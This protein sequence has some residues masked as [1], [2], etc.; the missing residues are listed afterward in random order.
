MLKIN[1]KSETSH[2]FSN[3]TTILVEASV[4][5]GWGL[6]TASSQPPCF[7]PGSHGMFCA[8]RPKRA[9][10]HAGHTWP[11]LYAQDKAQSPDH[12]CWAP[13]DLQGL[14]HPTSTF[15]S[16]GICTCCSWGLEGSSSSSSQGSI[17][18]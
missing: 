10:S 15:P 13:R 16:W 1:P 2:M 18:L 17:L 3:T 7:C 8:Q 14:L 5:S 12:A 9:F 6:S 4:S 11:L